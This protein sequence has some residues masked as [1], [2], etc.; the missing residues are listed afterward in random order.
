MNLLCF[1]NTYTN[2]S[3]IYFEINNNNYNTCHE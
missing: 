3:I 1:E 2:K